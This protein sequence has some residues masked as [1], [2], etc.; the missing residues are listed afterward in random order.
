M[1]TALITGTSSGL[2]HQVATILAAD[3]WEVIGTVRTEADREQLGEVPWE[4]L[5]ADMTDDVAVE[6]LGARVAERW[7]RLDAL[8][9]NAGIAMSGPFEELTAAELRQ[10]IDV[11]LVGPMV[12]T[13]AC[14]PALRQ[15]GGVVVQVASV[16]GR[17]AD[18]LMGAYNASK[19]GARRSQRGAGA[20]GRSARSARRDRHAGPVPHPHLAQRVP[21]RGQGVDRDV[22]RG[23]GGCRRLARLARGRLAG[24]GRLR[25]GDRGCCARRRA[26]R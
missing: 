7:G 8:V 10:S 24:L 1:R 21:G 17:T 14:L 4:V 2:G 16:S 9:N 3:G 11:N 25:A 23:L 5:V 13:R 19:F 26:R 18:P 20:R 22:R 15:A 6:R 12:L